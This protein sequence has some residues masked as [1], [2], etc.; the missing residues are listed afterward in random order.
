MRIFKKK[1]TQEELGQYDYQV[2]YILQGV[3]DKINELAS[4]LGYKWDPG[5]ARVNNYSRGGESRFGLDKTGGWVE[6]V[7]KP[8]KRKVKK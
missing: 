8:V 4:T 5:M 1:V 7:K 2:S 3:D 6:K